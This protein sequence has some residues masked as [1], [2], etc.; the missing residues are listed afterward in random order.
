MKKN[1]KS[2][3]FVFLIAFFLSLFSLGFL[4]TIGYFTYHVISQ[5]K[6]K[7]VEIQNVDDDNFLNQDE[8][9]KIENSS[10][11]SIIFNRKGNENDFKFGN[12]TI[13]EKPFKTTDGNDEYFLGPWGISL[14]NEMFKERAVFGPEIND[15]KSIRINDSISPKLDNLANGLYFPKEREIYIS[16]KNII[17]NDN[18]PI[19][20]KKEIEKKSIIAKR[21][22]TIFGTVMHEYTHHID[23]TYNKTLRSNDEL[24]NNDLVEYDDRHNHFFNRDYVATTNN[25]KFL[26]EFRKNLNYQDLKEDEDRNKY[27]RR[28]NDFQHQIDTIPVYK[29]FSSNELFRAANI[30]NLSQEEK[31]RYLELNNKKFFFNNNNKFVKIQFALPTDLN[32]IRYLFSLTELIPRELIKLS[33]GPNWWFYGEETNLINRLKEGSDLFDD[34]FY[35]QKPNGELVFNAAGVDILKNLGL[36][37]RIQ[38]G[39]L[40]FAPNW[41]FQEQIENFISNVRLGSNQEF[42]K[43]FK[44]IKDQFH[45]GLFKA[46]IDLMGFGELISFANFNEEN[47]KNI[48]FGGYF[49]IPKELFKFKKLN[50]QANNKKQLIKNLNSLKPKLLLVEKEN[51]KNY[52]EL[53]LKFQ[54]Y[55]FITKKQ[56]NSIYYF[57][58]KGN[59]LNENYYNEQWIYPLKNN[60][61][62]YVSYFANNSNKS[63]LIKK[64]KNKQFDLKLWIDLNQDGNPNLG[65]KNQKNNETFSLM[66]DNFWNNNGFDFFKKNVQNQRK[67]TTFRNS[68]LNTSS[69]YEWFKLNHD[70]DSKKYY[71]SIEEY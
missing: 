8:D 45:K 56:W 67:T 61:Y 6:I 39:L 50:S 71:Y 1:K 23:N 31:N 11:Q 25:K 24:A 43:P 53:D 4:A 64:F 54:K 3:K 47:K 69:K 34:F 33:L 10:D 68:F 38:N 66:N 32:Q 15:L 60:N 44:D 40:T 22:E 13:I 57:H 14:L 35:F 9:I 17:S 27:L 7:Y 18:N 20:Q 59:K 28:K 19:A 51:D 5:K 21:V 26:T 2:K 46:Y 70:Q 48:N 37:K 58:N 63:D 30:S 52:I 55:N 16:I 36:G 49:Q 65:E 29:E 42:I 62:T 41:V 12:L